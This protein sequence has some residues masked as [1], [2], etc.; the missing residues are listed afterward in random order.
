MSLG[1]IRK[2]TMYCFINQE[3]ILI[4][5]DTEVLQKYFK[6]EFTHVNG[7][8]SDSSPVYFVYNIIFL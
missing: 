3:E 8:T 4:F 7:W 2:V 5:S 1:N 6:G